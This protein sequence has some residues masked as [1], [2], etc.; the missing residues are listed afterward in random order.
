[1]KFAEHGFSIHFNERESRHNFGKHFLNLI[2][3]DLQLIPLEPSLNLRLLVGFWKQFYCESFDKKCSLFT[4]DNMINHLSCGCE[5]HMNFHEKC[6][7]CGGPSHGQKNDRAARSRS[8]EA[9]SH[10]CAK[11]SVKDHFTTSCS[12][13]TS[14]RKWDH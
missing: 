12:K 7:A 5:Y 9:W 8:Y 1:M 3:L 6:W 2:N 11:C 13:Y 14:C 4:V 10:T